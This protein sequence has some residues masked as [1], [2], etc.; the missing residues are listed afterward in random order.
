MYLG[1]PPARVQSITADPRN[2]SVM[3]RLPYPLI[4]TE[5]EPGQGIARLVDCLPCFDETIGSLTLGSACV[6]EFTRI[7]SREKIPLFLGPRSLVVLSGEARYDWRHAIP[8]RK[9]D[10]HDGQA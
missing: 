7:K 10:E 4:V 8:G 1:P 3:R 6:M 2:R 5:Y 9:S